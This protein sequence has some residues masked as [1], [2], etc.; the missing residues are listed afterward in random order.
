[1]IIYDYIFDGLQIELNEI[2]NKL[3]NVQKENKYSKGDYYD[4]VYLQKLK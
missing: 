4:N 1:M 3:L 2:K